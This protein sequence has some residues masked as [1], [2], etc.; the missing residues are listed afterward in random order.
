MNT[1]AQAVNHGTD[2]APLKRNLMISIPLIIAT[3]IPYLLLA[4]VLEVEFNWAVFGL[5]ALGWWVALVF[6]LPVIL[7]MRKKGPEGASTPIIA[8]SGP[9]EELVRLG[10]LFWLGFNL[11]VAFILGLGWAAIEILY[12][13]VQGV[14]LTN[15]A[16]RTDEKAMQA[17]ELLSQQMSSALDSNTPF[18]GI[19]ERLSANGLHL[20]FSLLLLVSPWVVMI[21]A[22]LHSAINLMFTGQAKQSLAR[23]QLRLAIA[24]ACLVG[25]S[26]WLVL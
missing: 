2:A 19:V 20:A 1:H 7:L 10:F 3:L 6:R 9:A 15:L 8:A 13:I 24:A 11:D 12:A 21:T 5:G 18:W 16:S 14:A 22:P 23:A 26:L 4:R 17:K 25:V